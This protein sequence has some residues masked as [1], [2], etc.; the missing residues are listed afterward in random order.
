[1]ASRILAHIDYLDETIAELS[2]EIER[3][4]DPFSEEIALLDTIP[5]V[6]RKVAEMIIAEIGVDMSRFP[7]HYHLASWA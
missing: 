6:N 1:M 3:V 7:T 4:L 5:G 2:S